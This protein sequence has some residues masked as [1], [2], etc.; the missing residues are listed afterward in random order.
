M[1]FAGDIWVLWN[2]NI[3][4]LRTMATSFQEVHLECKVSRKTFLLIAIYAS[5]L[6]ERRKLLWNF[7]MNLSPRLNIPWLLLG[8][9]NDIA[10]PSKKFGG[11]PPQYIKIKFFNTFLNSRGLIDLGFIGLPFTWI[12]G[13]PL[14]ITLGHV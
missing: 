5:P 9:F 12:N 10:I 7:F 13:S 1:G 8:D 14:V 3:V 11:G 2:P 4:N 6:F